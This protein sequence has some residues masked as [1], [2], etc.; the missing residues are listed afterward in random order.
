MKFAALFLSLL[1]LIAP[2]DARFM[3]GGATTSPANSAITVLLTSFSGTVTTGSGTFSACFGSAPTVTGSPILNLATTPTA[4]VATYSTVTGNCVVYAYS[5]GANQS[6][7]PVTTSSSAITGGS[8]TVGGVAANLTGANN[9]VFPGLVFAPSGT[10]ASILSVVMSPSTGL[11]GASSGV[12]TSSAAITFNGSVTATGSNVLNLTDGVSCAITPGTSTILTANCSFGAGSGTP[13]SGQNT[14]L[15]TTGS[16]ITGGTISNG[17]GAASLVN[18]NNVPFSLSVNPN[19]AYFIAP[20]GTDTGSGSGAC[21]IGSPCKTLDFVRGLAEANSIKYVYARGG[22]YSP[23]STCTWTSDQGS[24]PTVSTVVCLTSADN[25]TAWLGYPN[26]QPA[27]NLGASSSTTGVNDLFHLVGTSGVTIDGLTSNN[28]TFTMIATQAT[29]NTTITGNVCNG[30]YQPSNATDGYGCFSTYE[31]M[32]NNDIEYNLVMNTW[33]A[34]IMVISDSSGSVGVSGT[35]N[36]VKHNIILNTC[37]QDSDCGALYAYELAHTM[38]GCQWNDNV[39]V[40]FGPSA[41]L[42]N[43]IYNDDFMSNCSETQNQIGSVVG[44]TNAPSTWGINWHGGNNLLINGNLIDLSGIFSNTGSN[45]N[46]DLT[47]YQSSSSG[48]VG[49]YCG[50]MTGNQFEHNIV[51]SQVAPFTTSCVGGSL[52]NCGYLWIYAPNGV[53]ITAPTVTLND[54]FTTA[55]GFT[56]YGNN[57]GPVT[58]TSPITTNPGVTI[59][60]SASVCGWG[61]QVPSGTRC[62]AVSNPPAGFPGL[63]TGQG[64]H[65]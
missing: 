31:Q 19:T 36:F 8:I 54:Y 28:Q 7:N 64:P 53:S 43:A 39:I 22:S 51:W 26:E 45:H 42:S 15:G 37:T 40:N 24:D 17:A 52:F 9:W 11:L 16:A 30:V 60:T 2:A 20:T 6:A 25:N 21:Q 58:D 55:G 57:G 23:S 61:S 1:L 62:Y 41:S 10:P 56:N 14:Y 59:S 12:T 47:Y 46:P 44:Q 18:A 29:V 33:G 32:Q 34:G 4:G 65:H 35:Q 38:T 48:C 5:V 49:S 13:I 63:L 3:T 50:T 27:F